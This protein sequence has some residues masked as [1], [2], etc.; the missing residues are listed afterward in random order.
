MFIGT[1]A[2]KSGAGGSSSGMGAACG[3]AAEN[4]CGARKTKVVCQVG[5][6][7]AEKKA[8]LVIQS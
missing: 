2:R 8:A 6:G 7:F 3:A 4:I 1:G 5:T